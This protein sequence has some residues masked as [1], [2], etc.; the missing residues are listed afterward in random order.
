MEF[1]VREYRAT[2]FDRLWQIDQLCFPRGISYT[3]M[4]LSG[5]ITQRNALTLLAEI[6]QSPADEEISAF[7][8]R[9]QHD[10]GTLTAQ[11]PGTA[12]QT[13]EI[14]GFVIAHCMRRKTGRIMTLDVVPEARRQGLASQLMN[15]CE[16]EL[17]SLG[18]TEIFLETAVNNGP[19][20]SLYHKL[21]YEIL[22]TLPDY[23]ASHSLDAFL[24]GKRL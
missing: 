10:G 21:G 9:Q 17:R 23:Y 6:D 14:A 24:M 11:L 8:A 22:R 20:L 12:S 5:F 19:A 18:C 15:A 4:E 7:P 2:D 16:G 1:H 3:Q 13:R